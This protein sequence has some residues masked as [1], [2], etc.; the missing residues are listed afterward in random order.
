MKNPKKFIR[1]AKIF[2][3]Q[4]KDIKARFEF[5]VEVPRGYQEAVK[6]YEKNG[7]TKWQAL[8]GK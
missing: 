1:L 8:I 2:K 6:L 3:S 5:G 7:N 4:V